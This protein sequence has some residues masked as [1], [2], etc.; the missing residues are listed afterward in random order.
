MLHLSPVL[1]ENKHY[2]IALS[3]TCSQTCDL[4]QV[5]KPKRKK[6]GQNERSAN[7]DS[8]EITF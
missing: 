6:S 2:S 1:E 5:N 7:E 4:N 3:P 8:V